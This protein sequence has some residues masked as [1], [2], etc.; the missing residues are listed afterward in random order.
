MWI[1]KAIYGSSSSSNK[2]FQVRTRRFIQLGT[3]IVNIC[4][5]VGLHYLSKSQEM[6]VLILVR[7]FTTY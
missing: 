6:G 5:R 7:N 1:Y 2:A 4:L 3:L